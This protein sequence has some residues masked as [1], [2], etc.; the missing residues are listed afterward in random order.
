MTIFDLLD[1]YNIPYM[2][3][4]H[5]HCREGWVQIDCPFCT[6][7][8]QRWRMGFNLTY[9]YVHCWACGAHRLS[10]T[11]QELFNLPYRTCHKYT[12]LLRSGTHL[13]PERADVRGRLE[14]PNGIGPM[15]PAHKDYLAG[16]GFDP[17]QIEQ[18]YGAQGIGIAARLQWRIFIPIHLY[19]EIVSWTTRSI[20]NQGRR[21][22]SAAANQEK[23]NHKHLL[24]AEDYCRHSII[25]VEG[26]LDAWKI[27]YGGAGTFGTDFTME[28]V[29]RASKYTRRA[30]CFDSSDEAQEKAKELCRL[31]APFSGTT[32][33]V[34]LDAEDPGA[35]SNREIKRL[36]RLFLD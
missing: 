28:Q 3:E 32:H 20:A 35:A 21:Y 29:R 33:N 23:Y 15:L 17:I 6:P 36:R 8:A 19:G 16:R 9:A 18:R 31:L 11:F 1:R 26:P 2:T 7:H 24:Y 14:L 5:E 12:D 22:H 25:L 34:R 27:G 4:G 10:D 30:V 13:L